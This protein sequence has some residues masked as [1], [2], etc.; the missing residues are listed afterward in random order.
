[1]VQLLSP[2]VL[3]FLL[4]ISSVASAPAETSPASTPSSTAASAPAAA[5]AEPEAA[6]AGLSAQAAAKACSPSSVNK[7]TLKLL[8]GF[9]GWSAK[10]C[11]FYHLA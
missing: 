2:A 1:M 4:F 3:T 5:E 6:G 11:K 8:E 10:P 7:A 9:E